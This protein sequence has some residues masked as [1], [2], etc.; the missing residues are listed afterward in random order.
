MRR[1]LWGLFAAGLAVRWCY[2]FALYIWTGPDGLMG[3]DSYGSLAKAAEFTRQLGSGSL[4]GWAWLGP[5]ASLMPAYLWFLSGAMTVSMDTGLLAPVLLQG[6]VD[7]ATC[8]VI[9]LLAGV[10]DRRL[11]VPAVSRLPHKGFYATPGKSR[12]EKIWNFFTT[13]KSPVY[14]WV[15]FAGGVGVLAF[16]TIELFGGGG[17]RPDRRVRVTEIS[18]AARA[19]LRRVLR[20]GV[21]RPAAADHA[22]AGRIATG[23][24]NAES[25]A[26]GLQIRLL[27]DAAAPSTEESTLR[28]Y[29]ITTEQPADCYAL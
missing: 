21:R 26:D 22:Q 3:P 11:I 9:A 25:L 17:F 24:I 6:V 1:T 7:A 10:V 8:V 12:P 27:G 16:R 28:A 14:V 20:A 29:D 13:I 2:A 15:L 5:D 18:A 19:G 4:N 23:L